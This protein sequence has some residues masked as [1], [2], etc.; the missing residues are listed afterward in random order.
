MV[1][2]NRRTLE[3]D[4]RRTGGPIVQDGGEVFSGPTFRGRSED[5]RL[6]RRYPGG[7]D[8]GPDRLLDRHRLLQCL[9]FRQCQLGE[10]AVEAEIRNAEPHR[11]DANGPKMMFAN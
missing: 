5:T 4:L 9:E 7:Y 1:P 3:V 11:L 2:S 6:H 8:H 10:R